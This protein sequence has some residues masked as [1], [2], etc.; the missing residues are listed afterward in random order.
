MATELESFLQRIEGQPLAPEFDVQGLLGLAT[1]Q[2]RRQIESPRGRQFAETRRLAPGQQARVFL[3]QRQ[4]LGSALVGAGLQA[5]VSQSAAQAQE[6]GR[7]EELQFRGAAEVDRQRE[8][9]RRRG[10]QLLTSLIGTAASLGTSLPG[11]IGGLRTQ[12]GALGLQ[13]GRL[14]TGAET[15]EAKRNL[16][17]LLR[18]ILPG[19]VGSDIFPE[20]AGAEL[21]GPIS[22][23]PFGATAQQG[24]S[25][26]S[27]F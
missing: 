5:R 1:R 3:G 25:P 10:L 19:S 17:G 9:R 14:V 12:R 11:L 24:P 13:A 16:I 23:I 7:R 6:R 2:A 15:P 4:A 27:A 22:G 20:T 21:L 26:L 8:E 18:Q